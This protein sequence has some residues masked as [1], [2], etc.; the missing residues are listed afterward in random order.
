MRNTN[1]VIN[2][3]LARLW[4]K[5][6]PD[7]HIINAFGSILYFFGS[8]SHIF[9]NYLCD[10]NHLQLLLSFFFFGGGDGGTEGGGCLTSLCACVCA[11]LFLSSNHVVILSGLYNSMIKRIEWKRARECE[12]RARGREI[13]LGFHLVSFFCFF[14]FFEGLSGGS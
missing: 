10:F 12:R 6:S 13:G 9:I 11:V 8:S 3:V 7:L 5:R 4:L 1:F 14:F 2:L